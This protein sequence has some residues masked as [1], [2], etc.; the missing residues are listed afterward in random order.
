MTTTLAI[1]LLCVNAAA[2]QN[3]PPRFEDYPAPKFSGKP[4]A[5]KI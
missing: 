2:Q 1:F 5:V 4:A 3:A